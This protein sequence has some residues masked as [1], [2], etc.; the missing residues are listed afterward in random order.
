MKGEV[1]GGQ[2]RSEGQLGIG[3]ASN[4]SSRNIDMKCSG[5]G[6]REG[7]GCNGGRRALA[8]LVQSVQAPQFA[9]LQTARF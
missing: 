2:S 5:E 3:T 8:S 1:G 4:R 6:L 7:A 9:E